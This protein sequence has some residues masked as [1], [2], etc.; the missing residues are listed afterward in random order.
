MHIIYVDTYTLIRNIV[1]ECRILDILFLIFLI[2]IIIL[3]IIAFFLLGLFLGTSFL[4][5][6]KKHP[7]DNKPNKKDD[8]YNINKPCDKCNDYDKYNH[9]HRNKYCDNNRQN[10]D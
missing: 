3:L 2:V 7:K 6:K 9:C 10:F 1:R 8:P 4:C 5:P